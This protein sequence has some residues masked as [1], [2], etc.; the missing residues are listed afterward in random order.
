MALHKSVNPTIRLQ[1]CLRSSGP[2]QNRGFSAVP[3]QVS[4]ASALQLPIQ[5]ALSTLRIGLH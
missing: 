3:G 2:T 1:A 5:V 4:T